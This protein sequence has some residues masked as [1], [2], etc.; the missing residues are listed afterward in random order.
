MSRVKCP[1]CM[2]SVPEVAAFCPRCGVALTPAG[3]RRALS[4]AASSSP[5]AAAR[6]FAALLLTIVF[7]V[8]IALVTSATLHL[9]SI[10]HRSH[11]GDQRAE[12]PRL[13]LRSSV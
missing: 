2:K 10:D 5:G 6:S 3:H 13:W 9:P 8:F 7:G 4:P 11:W 1:R 12:Y